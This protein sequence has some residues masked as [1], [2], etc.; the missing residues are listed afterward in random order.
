[1][2]ICYKY[3]SNYGIIPE[4]SNVAVVELCE[5]P[6][7]ANNVLSTWLE[8]LEAASL[9]PDRFD[10]L[11]GCDDLLT[12]LQPSS[13]LLFFLFKPFSLLSFFSSFSFLFSSSFLPKISNPSTLVKTLDPFALVDVFLFAGG[14]DTYIEQGTLK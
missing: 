5:G 3:T 2:L 4:F 12:F 10:C 1:M 6:L 9:L 13:Q 11:G 14:G 8:D 7:N